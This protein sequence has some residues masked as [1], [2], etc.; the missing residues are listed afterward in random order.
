[1]IIVTGATG[2]LGRAVT[3]RLLDTVPAD[4]IGVSVRDPDK[5]ADL[6]ARGVRVRHGDFDEP[7]SLPA[8]FQGATRVLV[9]SANALGETAV[10]LN[11]AAVDAAV[12]AGA[13]RIVYTSQMGSDAS[14]AFP[15][16]HA[17]AATEQALQ[18]SGVA[19]TSLRNGFYATSAVMQLR[20]AL[21]S[22]ELRVPADG[23]FA[24]TAHADLADAAASALTGDTLDGI[25]PPLT[26]T[27]TLDM[28]AVA[29][30]AS[31]VLG[32]PIERIVVGDEEFRAGLVAA[33]R[34][35][36]V[37]DLLLGMF[38]AARAG[39]FSSTDPILEQVIGRPPTPFR[40]V[41]A[42]E[43]GPVG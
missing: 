20:P 39:A 22:G 1:M 4:K 19:F 11:R 36:P 17:H 10:R 40:A 9:V 14:S 35:Q 12:A 41:L 26:A 3:E 28:A 31:D 23:P 34:P 13:E 15:P 6:A 21:D 43:L 24:W 37:A 27:D 2:Q 38:V 8:A 16:M 32:R 29:A 33:G 18:G 7:E 42:E 25:T 5:A 30:A